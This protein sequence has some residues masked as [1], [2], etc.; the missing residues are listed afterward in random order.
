VVLQDGFFCQV[1]AQVCYGKGI[2]SLPKTDRPP[3]TRTSPPFPT[4]SIAVAEKKT[5]SAAFEEYLRRQ[6]I[7]WLKWI[8]PA[9]NYV[10]VSSRRQ[11]KTGSS[12][13]RI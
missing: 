3:K 13:E 4:I 2:S 7:F 5:I 1:K 10:S 8:I 12:R 9:L 11:N 6:I